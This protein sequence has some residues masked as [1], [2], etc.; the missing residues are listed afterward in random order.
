MI[1]LVSGDLLRADF[2][3][4]VN[5]VNCAGSMGRGIA[6]MFKRSFPENFEVYAAAC[7]RG[8]VEPGAMLVFDAGGPRN[9]PLHRQLPDQA[10]L[11]RKEPD[12]GHR[13]GARRIDSRGR[14][15]SDPIHC[16]SCARLWTRWTRL[17]R[18]EASNRARVLALA[19]GA[20]A[21]LRAGW[22]T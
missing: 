5:T 15:E 21:G 9:P 12:R 18:R 6:A 14:G 3:A 11:A 16:R 7:K 10:T 20:G 1:E 22:L 13:F 8:E 4:L 2:E 19:G 17:G